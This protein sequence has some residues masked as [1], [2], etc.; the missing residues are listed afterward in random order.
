MLTLALKKGEYAQLT[1]PDGTTHKIRVT[2]IRRKQVRIAFDVP[3]DWEIVRS[4]L[5]EAKVDAPEE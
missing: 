2:L 4:T 5:V 3:R 1:L